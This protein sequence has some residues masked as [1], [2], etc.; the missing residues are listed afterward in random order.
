MKQ[1]NKDVKYLVRYDNISIKIKTYEELLDVFYEGSS[2]DSFEKKESFL[3]GLIE[4]T[5]ILNDFNISIY[6]NYEE[7][8]KI[9]IKNNHYILCKKNIKSIVNILNNFNIAT[10]LEVI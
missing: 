4:L 9:K 5:A 6:N 7:F 8:Q 1:N 3:I 10:I 2:F